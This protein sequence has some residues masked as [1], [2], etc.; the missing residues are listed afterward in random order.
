MTVR[1]ELLPVSPV[2]LQACRDRGWLEDVETNR[3]MGF[4]SDGDGIGTAAHHFLEAADNGMLGIFADSRPVGWLSVEQDG[5]ESAKVTVFVDPASRRKGIGSEAVVLSAASLLRDGYRRVGAA[6]PEIN[7]GARTF[8]RRCGFKREGKRWSALK[9]DGR[10]YDTE[11]LVLTQ[12]EL[13]RTGQK[14]EG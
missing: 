3:Q 11:Q 7:Q 6:V 4:G 1:I 10:E 2:L 14:P 9:I 12:V 8:F 13:T 5:D